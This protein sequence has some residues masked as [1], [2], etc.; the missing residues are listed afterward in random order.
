[1]TGGGYGRQSRSLLYISHKGKR[2]APLY[3][4]VED[5]AQRG[6]GAGVA[7]RNQRGFVR[8]A[9]HRMQHFVRHRRREQNQQVRRAYILHLRRQLRI[10]LGF[11][12]VFAAKLDITPHH[13]FVSAH[14]NYAHDI[15]PYLVDCKFYINSRLRLC[16]VIISY[17]NSIY[18][19]L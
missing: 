16:T 1:M 13:T 10:Y 18:L 2:S 4:R 8:A 19:L 3:M 15:P 5:P 9:Q 7:A 11:T 17:Q 12:A 6:T 14:N